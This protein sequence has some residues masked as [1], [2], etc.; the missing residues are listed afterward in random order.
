[1]K[2]KI[3]AIILGIALIGLASATYP[4]MCYDIEFPNLA[5]VN[6]TLIENTSSFDGFTW[7]KS[8]YDITYCFST[9]FAV[10]N[11]TLEWSNYE[12]ELSEPTI[13]HHYSSSGGGG[14]SS[15]IYKDRNITKYVEVDNYIDRPVNDTT[16]G[17]EDTGDEEENKLTKAWLI[18]GWSLV[19]SMFIYM[20]VS[21]I[22]LI[23][24]RGKKENEYS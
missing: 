16:I 18:I 24:N 21:I 6:F 15:I 17:I 19:G 7:E 20:V 13:V 14:G 9:D 22:R 1:M 2:N 10:G 4:G 12:D 3:V 11:Y 5:E 23:R 8:G